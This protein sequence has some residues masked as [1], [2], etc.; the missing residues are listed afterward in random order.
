[1]KTKSII[2]KGVKKNGKR[3]SPRNW[4]ERIASNT[5]LFNHT[6]KR[7]TY[8]DFVYPCIVDGHQ[9]VCMDKTLCEKN[10]DL[11]KSILKFAEEN[12]LEI[13]FGEEEN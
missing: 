12:D 10:P 13:D 4:A 3:F 9:A 5:A 6:D 8:S 11:Y 2:I 1:V 7:L